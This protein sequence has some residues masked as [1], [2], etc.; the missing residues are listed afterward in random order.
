MK[1]EV[2]T[3]ESI[4]DSFLEFLCQQFLVER[5]DIELDKSLVDTGIIDSMGLIEI[6]A[7]LQREY[8]IKITEEK[9]NRNNFGSV[10]KIV[11]FVTR[12]KF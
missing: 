8:D 6:S 5:E 7:Y 11:D 3:K 4:Q 9:M 12:E 2:L 1:A 10:H